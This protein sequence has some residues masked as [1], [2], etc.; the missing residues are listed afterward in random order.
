MHS[1]QTLLR[2]STPQWDN[3]DPTLVRVI[4]IDNMMN[5]FASRYRM[6]AGRNVG[7]PREAERV[8]V[9]YNATTEE[10]IRRVTAQRYN[11]NS[12]WSLGQGG[13]SMDLRTV[14]FRTCYYRGV[15]F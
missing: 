11:E 1:L 10:V 7:Q 14:R 9:E 13:V 6:Q 4:G 5:V 8:V 15:F 12:T 3:P 2:G